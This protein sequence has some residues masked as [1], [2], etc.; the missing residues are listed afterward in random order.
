M[1]TWPKQIFRDLPVFFGRC[2]KQDARPTRF[3]G[4]CS[5]KDARP[6]RPGGRLPQESRVGAHPALSVVLFLALPL[7]V[8]PFSQEHRELS[9]SAKQKAYGR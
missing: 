8:K 1:G 7:T 2:P 5:E 6:A 3:F 4:R 9:L